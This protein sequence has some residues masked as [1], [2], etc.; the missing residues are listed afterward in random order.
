[1]SATALPALEAVLLIVAVPFAASG[2]YLALLAMCARRPSRRPAAHA[3]RRFEIVV[4]AHD[5][6]AVIAPTLSSLAALAYPA[7]RYRITVVADNC[8]DRTAAIARARGARVLER[9]DTEQRGKGHALAY[10]FSDF[11]RSSSAEAIVVVDADTVVS[12]ELLAEFAAQLDAGAEV[13]QAR[14]AVRDATSGWRRRLMSLAF[15][16]FHDVR[17]LGR[18]RLGLSCGL[19]GNGMC[20]TRRALERV[21]YRAYSLVEDL[22][23]GIA[24]GLAG[25]RVAYAHH[26]LVRGDMPTGGRASRTQRDRWEQG[27][28][29]IARRYRLPLLRAAAQRRDAVALDLALD[30]LVPPLTTLSVVSALGALIAAAAWL[31]GWTSA[32]PTLAWACAVLGLLVYIARGCMLAEGGSRVIADLAWA[33]VYMAWKL[34]PSGRAGRREP[35]TEWIRTSRGTER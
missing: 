3:D 28:T 29:A 14:Y 21:P 19:R 13:V 2:A 18:E 5:E 12:P 30:L 24:L 1:M 31:A 9:E 22:E 35:V 34:L 25:V 11:L 4:P 8:T 7:D 32:A 20:F 17:S 26:A 15:A 33:P 10:A 27:R 6:E 23:H 16:L